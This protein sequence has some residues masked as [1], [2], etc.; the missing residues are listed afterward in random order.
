MDQEAMGEVLCVCELPLLD[1]T[2]VFTFV[3][4]YKGTFMYKHIAL[5]GHV[6]EVYGKVE[7]FSGAH[8][9]DLEN[10]MTAYDLFYKC[11]SCGYGEN[12]TSIEPDKRHHSWDN[13]LY[14]DTQP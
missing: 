2:T 9:I 10:P 1:T 3:N 12:G 4:L 8:H 11:C 5:N 6:Y 14:D 7:D 13:V